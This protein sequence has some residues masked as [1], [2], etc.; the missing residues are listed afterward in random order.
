MALDAKKKIEAGEKDMADMADDLN[1]FG[2]MAH[3]QWIASDD[4]RLKGK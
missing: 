3:G 1:T 4:P 2:R